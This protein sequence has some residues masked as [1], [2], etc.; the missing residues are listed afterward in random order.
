M[1][2]DIMMIDRYKTGDGHFYMNRN[3]S[4]DKVSV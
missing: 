2:L 3:L 4:Y 1:S